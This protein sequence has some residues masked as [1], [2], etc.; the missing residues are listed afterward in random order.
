MTKR[1]TATGWTHLK[2]TYPDDVAKMH[3]LNISV[4]R[5][6]VFLT[7]A[8]RQKKLA[9]I[10][11]QDKITNVDRYGQQLGYILDWLDENCNDMYYAE[12]EGITQYTSDMSIG[13]YFMEETDA[14]AFKLMFE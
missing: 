9:K 14:M 13:F 4:N 5:F 6:N 1:I 7:R 2:K 8:L 11:K 3:H 12:N 10:Q